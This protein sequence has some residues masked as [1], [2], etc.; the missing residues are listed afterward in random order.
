MALEEEQVRRKHVRCY[1]MLDFDGVL[2]PVD[3]PPESYFGNLPLLEI[4]LRDY[5][6]VEV[7]VTSSWRHVRSLDAIRSN[8]SAD[9]RERIVGA[10]PDIPASHGESDH[11]TRHEEVL[12]WLATNG[13]AK[14]PWVAL[15]DVP[16]LYKQD[17]VVVI[18]RDGFDARAE[19]DLRSAFNRLPVWR[20]DSR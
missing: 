1:L 13:K 4:V 16:S 5:P 11:G 15:D 9:L 18:V 3:G 19:I 10:T 8:F 20:V 2:H 17:A 6:L 12:A 7:V 14:I